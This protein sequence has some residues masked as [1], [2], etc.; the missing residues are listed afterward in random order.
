MKRFGSKQVI[1]VLGLCMA[2][3]FA[4]IGLKDLGF[5]SSKG[6][7]P[8]FFPTIMGILMGAVCVIALLGSWKEQAPTYL[9]ESWI[10]VL[11]ALMAVLSTFVIGLIPS[12]LLFI[13]LWLKVFE[14]APWSATLKI[15]AIM[16]A[17]IFGVFVFW[18]K[19]RFPL[20][21]V[22]ELIKDLL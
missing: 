22:G 20:G 6:P 13:V 5:W 4:Y 10:L 9:K 11:A 2:M 14:K 8:G 3:A 12:V 19:V 17:I 21:I 15:L 1:P 7:L 16:S 18:L